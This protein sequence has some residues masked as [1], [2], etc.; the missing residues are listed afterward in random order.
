[1]RCEPCRVIA[2]RLVQAIGTSLVQWI[3]NQS[4]FACKKDPSWHPKSTWNSDYLWLSDFDLDR[5]LPICVLAGDTP[6]TLT[7]KSMSLGHRLRGDVDGSN[8]NLDFLYFDLDLGLPICVL[9]LPWP[10]ICTELVLE[11]FCDRNSHNSPAWGV[12]TARTAL[13]STGCFHY[14]V[15]TNINQERALLRANLMRSQGTGGQWA[16]GEVNDS[17]I[18]FQK[19]CIEY[20]I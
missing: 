16:A 1:M 12:G 6:L 4:I 18:I 20:C 9:R 19:L 5:G 15:T 17:F 11:A 13:W 7:P 10:I 2:S 14:Q 3:Y 8:Q